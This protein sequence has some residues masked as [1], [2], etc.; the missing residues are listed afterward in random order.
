M[1]AVIG[2]RQRRLAPREPR[3]NKN[4]LIA[5]LWLSGLRDDIRRRIGAADMTL[6]DA[7]AGKLG[8]V[9]RILAVA[10]NTMAQ[11]TNCWLVTIGQ[12]G[13]PNAR[14][15]S[16]IPGVEGEEEWTIWF[17]TSRGSRKVADIRRDDRITIGYQHDPDSAYVVLAGRGTI[18]EDRS[19]IARRWNQSWN[20]VFPA[21]AE[22]SD[23]LFIKG[24]IDRIELWNLAQKVTPAPFGKRPAILLRDA[25]RAWSCRA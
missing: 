11:V 20:R 22:D 7:D 18:S 19:E 2:R 3:I 12:H 17:L 4:A 24:K 14:V 21:G 16:P 13:E 9:D 5:L 15:V 25:T 10:R 1:S 6:L 8:Q 23:A